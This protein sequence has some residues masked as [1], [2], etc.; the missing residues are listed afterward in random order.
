MV[1]RAA[2]LAV[3]VLMAFPAIGATSLDALRSTSR[4]TR[5]QV[6]QLKAEQLKKRSELSA[7]SSRIEA[8][9]AQSKGRLLPG[10]ELDTALKASQ[11]LSGALTELAQQ[12]SARET[13][14]EA[15]NLALL[16]G[17]SGELNRL[18]AE[19]DRQSDR[20][21]RKG[22][23]DQMRKLR[24]ERDALRA[25]LPAAKLPT[26]DA[27]K[28][29]DD[30]EELLEQADLLRDNEEKLEKELKALDARIAERREEAELDQRVQRFMGEE[31]MFDDQ[32][33][34]LR[35]Q[36]TT[37]LDGTAPPVQSGS[38]NAPGAGAEY[39]Q[40]TAGGFAP[41]ASANDASGRGPMAPA[42]V[43]GLDQGGV[44]IRS[45]SDARPQVGSA[46]PNTIATGDEDLEDL[47]VQRAKL[48][49]LA[50]EL[51]RKAAELEKRASQL[52]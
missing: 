13:E 35:V 3:S 12:V 45:G 32:D 44:S 15:A 10:G 41:Q 37:T 26:L 36:R 34:R 38:P 2:L 7:L 1:F 19:F 8:L 42:P 33:R 46:N 9:K 43:G 16:D 20:G 31:S 17:L 52:R 48:K 27:V 6:S 14:L 39:S 21:K 5:D 24:A 22:L 25:T 18:R 51:K 49:G 30:P 11:E 28:P 4:A 50:D 47:E 40:D 29:S 23:I